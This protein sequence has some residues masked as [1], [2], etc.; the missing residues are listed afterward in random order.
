[1]PGCKECGGQL[2]IFDVDDDS[3]SVGCLSCNAEYTVE[4]DG[5]GHGGLEWAEAMYRKQCTE[6]ENN[7]FEPFVYKG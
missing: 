2:E 3:I 4:P 7:I 6:A 5:L 1:M